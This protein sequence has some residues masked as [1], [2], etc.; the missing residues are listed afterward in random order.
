VHQDAS[1]K[2]LAMENQR[3]SMVT[4]NN[5]VTFEVLNFNEEIPVE[6]SKDVM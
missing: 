2:L 1:K 3:K 5:S 6:E 4:S